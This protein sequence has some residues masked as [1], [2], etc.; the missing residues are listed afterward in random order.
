MLKEIYSQL[1]SES[2]RSKQAWREIDARVNVL[3]HQY[4][5]DSADMRRLEDALT[6][7]GEVGMEQG[8]ILG[9]RFA[10]VLITEAMI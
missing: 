4:G 2:E 6:A 9:T 3:M 10:M 1:Y 5:G 7:A 8:F